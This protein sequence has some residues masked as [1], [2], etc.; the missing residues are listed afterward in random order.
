ML[1]SPELIW[2]LA[3]TAKGDVDAFERLYL[4]TR[5]K[6]YGVALRILRKPE[7]ADEVMQEAYVRIWRHA[8][9]FNPRVATPITWMVA[10]ARNGALDVLRKRPG[11]VSEDE[12]EAAGV[13]VAAVD[14][15][16][17]E[18]TDQLR[19]LLACMGALEER[20]RYMLLL[21]YYNGWSRDQ[22]ARKLDVPVPTIREWLSQGLVQIRECLGR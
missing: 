19:L 21:A 6:I 8:G 14:P 3:A 16:R 18:M 11:V 2:L 7:L 9:E 15:A 20:Q 5:S 10:I 22:L 1:A 4:A 12:P 13:S 17:R